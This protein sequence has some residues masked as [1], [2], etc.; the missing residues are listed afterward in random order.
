[1]KEGISSININGTLMDN[2]QVTAHIFNNYFSTMGINIT[3]RISQL[4]DSYSPI[5]MF[6]HS[7]KFSHTSTHETGKLIKSF[8]PKNSQNYD[9]ISVKVLKWSTPCNSSPLTYICNK[10][11]KLGIF[12][13]RLE[14]LIVNPTPKTGDRF[15]IANC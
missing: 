6:Y 4:H 1:M 11:Y 13:S 3:D 8:K 12:P 5:S 2:Q 7:I 9:E 15:T 14:F 10:C